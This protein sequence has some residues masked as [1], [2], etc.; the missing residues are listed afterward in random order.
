MA[1]PRS[2]PGGFDS[3]D[4]VGD[5]GS[6]GLDGLVVPGPWPCPSE[7]GTDEAAESVV[8]VASRLVVE[9]STVLVEGVDAVVLGTR[10]VV[11]DA[12]EVAGAV[13]GDTVLEDPGPVPAGSEV[14]EDDEGACILLAAT[15]VVARSICAVATRAT[16]PRI[17]RESF[18][19]RL[20][21]RSEPKP[22]R[23]C[24]STA[25]TLLPCR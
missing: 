24:V 5:E 25:C 4:V 11:V 10:L 23:G 7:G 16:T 2:A 21:M 3:T 17:R 15:V 1:S 19:A 13:V 14:V 18:G 6:V 12:L 8:V 9:V 22:P 20:A